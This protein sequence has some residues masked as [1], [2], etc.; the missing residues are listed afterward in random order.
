MKALDILK[1]YWGH[2]SFR[3]NQEEIISS[4]VNKQ[5]TLALLP[6]GGGK[7]IC[8]QIPAIMN[9]GIC[10]VISP[11]I[12]LMNDQIR[13]L[14]SK[15]IK[16]V[17]I[18][19]NMYFKDIDTTLTNC[20]YGNIKFLYLSPEK[21]KNKLV[22][23][24]IRLMD[25]NLIAV[26]EAHC[27]SQWGH[28]FRP[29]YRLINEIRE[30]A[31]NAPII[32]LTAT[33]N[34]LVAEDIQENLN[35]KKNNLIKSSFR[36]KNLSYVNTVVNNKTEV[37]LKL[38]KKIKSSVIV[39]VGSR[40]QS[41]EICQL[42]INNQI[43]AKSYHAGIDNATRNKTQESW[44]TNQTRVIVAT[45]AFGLGIDKEDVKLVVHMQLPLNIEAYFQ[46]AGRAGRNGKTAYSFLLINQSDIKRNKDILKFRY[47]TLEEIQKMYQ[48]IA[49]YLQVAVNTMPEEEFAFNIE[50]FAKKYNFN[51]TQTFHTLQFLENEDL[52]KL[53]D[54]SFGSSKIK[55]AINNSELYKF[56]IANSFFDNFIRIILRKFPGIFNNNISIKEKK[57]ASEL[58]I[59]EEKLINMLQKLEQ[60]GIISY[61]PKHGGTH[62]IY[63][64][65]RLDAKELNISKE[66]LKE[67]RE[68]S[69][70]KLEEI[71]S[72]A[73]N[74]DE[75]RSILLLRHFGENS[76]ERCQ[77]CDYCVKENRK[78]LKQKDFE[79]ISAAIIKLLEK[80]ELSIDEIIIILK[81]IEEE[82]IQNVIQ[83]LFDKD[84]ISKHGNKY[85]RIKN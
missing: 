81:E 45:N 77:I 73:Y 30:F 27:I 83:Y 8:Y 54:N 36:R 28:N 16:S 5:D 29:S 1:K 71:I 59:S 7:S 6:T 4:V 62:L 80:R 18:S 56:Q 53:L 84:K 75:C 38:L 20:I 79:E 26:D 50:V 72:Y 19:S 85:S 11:L 44:I 17:S 60:K 49:D 47:P 42:L 57:L 82:K 68:Y 58:N 35:F 37:L 9:D 40:R 74:R 41:N 15:G 14:Q 55:M 64:Q 65:N 48:K 32:A 63:L 25:I 31:N 78:T 61:I 2:N 34:K 69:N 12:S 76:K 43:S 21:L 39:Y 67:A 22:R 3:L 66:R 23:D 33:A 52:I 13:H 70:K 51:I 10:L 24:K 46:E